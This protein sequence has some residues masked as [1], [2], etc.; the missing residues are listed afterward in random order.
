M[1]ETKIYHAATA[2]KVS[3]E[4]LLVAAT[5]LDMIDGPLTK[6]G[7][8]QPMGSLPFLKVS[9]FVEGVAR[10]VAKI[11]SLRGVAEG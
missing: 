3:L 4:T 5:L 11:D 10:I 7:I 1:S 9:L 2:I 8:A 6:L